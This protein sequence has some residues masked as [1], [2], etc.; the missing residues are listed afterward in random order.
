MGIIGKPGAKGQPETYL[1]LGALG[2]PRLSP[3][4]PCADTGLSG[5]LSDSCCSQV[6][7]KPKLCCVTS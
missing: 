6:A 5:G 2:S 3:E 7:W 4:V 1:V